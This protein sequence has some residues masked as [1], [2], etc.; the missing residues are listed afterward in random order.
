MGYLDLCRIR[1]VGHMSTKLLSVHVRR[2]CQSMWETRSESAKI[3]IGISVVGFVFKHATHDSAGAGGYQTALHY[4]ERTLL[5]WGRIAC[6]RRKASCTE[7][8]GP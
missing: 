4:C 7:P 2:F 1:E 8:R 6:I 5:N 3:L